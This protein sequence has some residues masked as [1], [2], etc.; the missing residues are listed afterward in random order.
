M[1]CSHAQSRYFDYQGRQNKLEKISAVWGIFSV[2][3]C[4]C[5]I[6]ST[7]QS[8]KCSSCPGGKFW[9]LTITLDNRPLISL[10]F[11][12]YVQQ[13]SLKLF[14]SFSH[15]RD[16]RVGGMCPPPPPPAG[17]W[18]PLPS[19][20]FKEVENEVCCVAG[21]GKSGANEFIFTSFQ[22]SHVLGPLSRT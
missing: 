4:Y 22:I 2:T 20:I 7:V 5:I 6:W 3:G 9:V 12:L 15:L 21:H 14:I 8:Q 18:M 10:N 11:V 19:Q 1:I 17:V 13:T 16:L